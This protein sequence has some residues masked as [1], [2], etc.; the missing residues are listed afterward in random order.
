[1][2]ISIH[3]IYEELK[4]HFPITSYKA[5]CG[6]LVYDRMRIFCP[7]H[8]IPDHVFLIARSWDLPEKIA[9]PDH[10]AVISIGPAA[11]YYNRKDRDYIELSEACDIMD[12]AEVICEVLERYHQ[13]HEAMQQIL[14][15]EKGL[16]ALLDT[17]LPFFTNPIYYVDSM[18]RITAYAEYSELLEVPNIYEDQDTQNLYS[19]VLKFDPQTDA[20]YK[21]KG[22]GL[23]HDDLLV[24]YP[25]LFYNVFEQEKVVGRFFVDARVHD[26]TEADYDLV[27][28]FGPVLTQTVLRRNYMPNSVHRKIE[29]AIITII[30]GGSVDKREL[31][32]LFE[33]FHWNSDY[34]FCIV[35]SLN[36]EDTQSHVDLATANILEKKLPDSIV[37]SYNKHII[38][39]IQAAEDVGFRHDYV[40][41]IS[42]FLR[43]RL[44]KASVSGYFKEINDIRLCYRQAMAA[45]EEGLASH[46]QHWIFYYE[47]VML[48]HM[49][50]KCQSDLKLRQLASPGLLRL[51]E[52]DQKKGSEYL[53]TLKTYLE[54]NCSPTETVKKLYLSRSTFLRRLERIKR[55]LNCNLDNV[56]DRLY[57]MILL[58]IIYINT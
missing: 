5:G 26:F 6:M 40:S 14:L 18:I 54:N 55:I 3:I 31:E 24:N 8:S 15:E 37:F 16:Q 35:V 32:R 41:Q 4:K 23:W 7:G 28:L 29:E 21:V 38:A 43:D 33:A 44:L 2:E 52:Y 13:W 10:C 45:L 50:R 25:S 47:N 51:M 20:S 53:F 17:A 39:I 56:D 48:S 49:L 34:Y 1:M 12:V 19:E 11:M 30:E 9:L 22:T 36:E 27:T 46:S 58:K 57:L 42:P